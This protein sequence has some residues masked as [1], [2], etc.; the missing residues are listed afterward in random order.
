MRPSN[1]HRL[2][3]NLIFLRGVTGTGELLAVAG[4]PYWPPA[5]NQVDL[6]DYAG[7]AMLPDFC[8][9]C[10]YDYGL[11]VSGRVRRSCPNCKAGYKQYGPEYRKLAAWQAMTDST[12]T[13]LLLRTYLSQRVG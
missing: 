7:A 13:E 2:L 8:V 4:K 11:T 10:M 12:G 3:F 5:K 1:L 9:S 6:H